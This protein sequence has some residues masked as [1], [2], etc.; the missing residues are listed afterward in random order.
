MSDYKSNPYTSTLNSIYSL[1]DDNLNIL[2][3]EQ[4]KDSFL[5]KLY[6]Y[7]IH[8][9]YYNIISTQIVNIIITLF[10]YFFLLFLFNCIDYNGLINLEDK[11]NFSNYINW[12]NMLRLDVVGWAFF[13]ILILFILCKII[14][15]IDDIFTFLKIRKFYNHRLYITDSQLISID[16]ETIVLKIKEHTECRHINVYTVASKV[17]AKDNFL[18]SLINNNVIKFNYMTKLMEWN[19]IFCLI[20]TIYKNNKIDI[21]LL[22]DEEKLNKTFKIKLKAV[23]IVN[24]IFMPFIIIFILFYNIFKYGELFYNNPEAISS[25]NWTLVSKWKFRE[26]N[27]LYHLFHERLNI[28]NKLA[29]DYVNQFPLKI[30]ETFSRLILFISSSIFLLF[31]V[32][33]IINENLL[34]NLNITPSRPVLWYI[35]I[36]GSI[37]ALSRNLI[38]NRLIYYPKEKM[39]EIKKIINYIPDEWIEN[40][41]KIYIKNKFIKLFEYSI[42]SAI[43]EFLFIL[44]TPIELWKLTYKTEDIVDFYVNNT[45]YENKIG[46]KCADAIFNKN[47][48]YEYDT[49]IKP[50][51]KQ[52]FLNFT[53]KHPNWVDNDFYSNSLQVNIRNQF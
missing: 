37:I 33:T 49:D 13:T 26:Y 46:Y 9:G 34:I 41:H 5:I 6:Y 42:V 24:F 27:E 50:K 48:D 23:S 44:Y 15:L 51:I 45:I 31:L 21:D 12:S 29:N 28:S 3:D 4:I 16:W 38:K 39:D 47:K 36:L 7:Y 22:S 43:K 10:L 8:K 32:L 40:S 17:M 53:K 1:N 19:I 14:S 18:I 2:N 25:R 52:S 30:L 35:G 11:D 20:N